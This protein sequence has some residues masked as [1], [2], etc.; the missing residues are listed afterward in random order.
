MK[1]KIYRNFGVL[2]NQILSQNIQNYP[3]YFIQELGEIEMNQN[4]IHEI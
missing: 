4:I 3:I 2:N 1:F